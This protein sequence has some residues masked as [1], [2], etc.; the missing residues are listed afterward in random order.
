MKTM[1][2][3]LSVL[4]GAFA[5][6]L[7]SVALASSW[8]S[9]QR[10]YVESFEA[11]YTVPKMQDV[12]PMFEEEIWAGGII[13]GNY[14][15][16]NSRKGGAVKYH[17]VGFDEQDASNT[18]VSVEIDVKNVSNSSRISSGGLIYRFDKPTATYYA[19][20]L[21][22]QGVAYFFKRSLSGFVNLYAGKSNAFRADRFNKLAVIGR[23]GVFHLYVNDSLQTT[24]EDDELKS[25]DTGIVGIGAGQYCFD[26][27]SIYAKTEELP[28]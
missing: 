16:A 10:V 19:F 21:S 23:G 13:D 3:V 6:G 22:S 7:G 2:R 4:I 8:A 28:E 20:T 15:Y 27:F 9:L 25:G 24:I 5:T 17:Y 1:T 18:P 14:C 12:W 11:G 26:N